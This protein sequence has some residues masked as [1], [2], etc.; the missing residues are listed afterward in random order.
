MV[1]IER[2]ELAEVCVRAGRIRCRIAGDQVQV[3]RG[4]HELAARKAQANG[5]PI[6]E[7]IDNTGKDSDDDSSDEG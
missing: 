6:P 3:V 1:G 2:S 4:S 7:Q 5:E